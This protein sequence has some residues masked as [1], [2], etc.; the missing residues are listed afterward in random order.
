VASETSPGMMEAAGHFARR[1]DRASWFGTDALAQIELRKSTWTPIELPPVEADRPRLERCVI[2]D[3]ELGNVLSI[4]TALG[5]VGVRATISRDPDAIAGAHALV[6]P[7]VGAF[8]KAMDNLRRLRLEAPLRGAVEE[9]RVP[10]LGICLGMQIMAR[11]SDEHGHHAGLGWLEM[12]VTRL[13]ATPLPHVGWNQIVPVRDDGFAEGIS[14]GTSLYFDHGY[15]ALSTGG[16]CEIATCEYG[17]RFVAVARN[18]NIFATQFHPEKSQN[19]GQR[20]L[21]NFAGWAAEQRA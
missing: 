3:Y 20:L 8:A 15:A 9:R 12:D 10:V 2:V 21:S 19:A 7:G 17:G 6:L 16:P 4:A 13:S 11:S 1:I 5:R 18:A 14:P